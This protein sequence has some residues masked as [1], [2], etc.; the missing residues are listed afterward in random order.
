MVATVTVNEITGTAGGKVYT[1]ISNRVRLFSADQATDQ[2]TPQTTNP[3]IIPASGDYY[4]YWKAICLDLAGAGFI[5]SNIRHYSAG[6]INWT[7]GTGGGIRRGNRDSGDIGCPD[8]NYQEASGLSVGHGAG[9]SGDAIEDAING[10]AYYNA[11]SVPVSDL[12][13]DLSGSPPVVDA[14]PHTVAEKTNHIV[15]QVKVDDD[16]VQGA[17]TPKQFTWEYDEQ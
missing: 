2:G 5:I 17:Q 7:W 10:H 8:A 3:V 11:Q 1:P 16:A 15:V 13:T 12:N 6:D 14:G 9:I 4:S